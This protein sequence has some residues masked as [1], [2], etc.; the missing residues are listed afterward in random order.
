MAKV[1]SP[2]EKRGMRMTLQEL[3]RI[4][5]VNSREKRTQNE[6]SLIQL[7]LSIEYSADTYPNR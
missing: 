7:R 6:K 2:A 3:L 1:S 4:T 5:I